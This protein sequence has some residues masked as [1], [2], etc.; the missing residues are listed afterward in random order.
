[1]GESLESNSARMKKKMSCY[2]KPSCHVI[3]VVAGSKE[4]S[5]GRELTS[6]GVES[7]FGIL[8]HLLRGGRA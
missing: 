3:L 6:S 2:G 8:E 4:I 7:T 5:M 1:M